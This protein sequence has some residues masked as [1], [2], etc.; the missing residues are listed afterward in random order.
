MM[1]RNVAKLVVAIYAFALV[2]IIVY[3]VISAL[4][5]IHLGYGG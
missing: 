2:E 3:T 5:P 1:I 4:A